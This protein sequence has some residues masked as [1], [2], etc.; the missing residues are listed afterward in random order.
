MACLLSLAFA[1]PLR[2][3]LSTLA[4]PRSMFFDL[5]LHSFNT[6]SLEN[7]KLQ[8]FLFAGHVK[9]YSG[10]PRFWSGMGGQVRHLL[11]FATCM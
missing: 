2:N 9:I 7:V 8:L 11:D 6:P 5:A 3:A 4:S 10:I 1:W